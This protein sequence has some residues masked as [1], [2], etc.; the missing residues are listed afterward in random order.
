M[1]CVEDVEVLVGDR[2]QRKAAGGV[3]DD[4]DAAVFGLDPVEHRGHGVLV[5]DVG[6]HGDATAARPLDLGDGVLGGGRPAGVVDDDREAVRGE[7][8][9]DGAA[10]AARAAG[11]QG[12]AARSG[13][14]R[15]SFQ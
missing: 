14:H 4:V 2:R 7:P 11:D 6:L 13:A 3:H 9:R 15:L 5:R 10:D 12:D 1:Q 8:D